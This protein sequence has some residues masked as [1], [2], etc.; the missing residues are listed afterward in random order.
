[1]HVCLLT[2]E[3]PLSSDYGGIATYMGT[4]ARA[5]SRAGSRVTVVA[6]GPAGDTLTRDGVTVHVVGIPDRTLWRRVRGRL[7][8]WR[9]N[10]IFADWAVRAC[11][12]ARQV[13]AAERIDVVEAPEYGAPALP[14]LRDPFAPLVVKCH[15]PSRMVG[16]AE[17]GSLHGHAKRELEAQDA[18]E[19]QCAAGATL[20]LVPHRAMAFALAHIW[21]MP[22]SSFEAEPNPIDEVFLG[23]VGAGPRD[24]ARFLFVGRP[25][26]RKGFPELIAAFT[27]VHRRH[28]DARLTLA[29]PRPAAGSQAAACL[30]AMPEAARAAVDLLGHCSREQLR[31]L[32]STATA[33]VVPSNGIEAFCYTAVE[34]MARGCPTIATST[35]GFVEWLLPDPPVV[36]VPPGDAAAL[37]DAMLRLLADRE[38]RERLAAECRRV[39]VDRFAPDALAAAKLGRFAALLRGGPRPQPEQPDPLA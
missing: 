15:G 11:A 34:A 10:A 19:R 28:P 17:S 18:R 9:G 39:V 21:W 35:A 25:E 1:M 36:S 24:A 26:R 33:M 6:A 14:L 3:Y 37:A 23:G 16:T 13:H 20:R 7:M 29:G 8:P 32:L 31:D 27:A 4:M 12:R 2:F 22:P 5:L 38:Q 30:E